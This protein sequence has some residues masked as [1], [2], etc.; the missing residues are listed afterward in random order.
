MRT[1]YRVLAGLVALGVVIQAAA[2]VYAVAGLGKYIDDGATINADVFEDDS[3]SFTGLGGFM[4]HGMNGMMIIPVLA[5]LL[6]IVSFF[7]KVPKGVMWA[8]LILLDVIL[9]VMLGIFGHEI[10]AV[11][12]LHGINAL[13][14][15]GLAVMA[16]MRSREP[17]APA[18][19]TAATVPGTT[20]TV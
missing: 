10:P 4:L 9:Q 14:L 17:A 20:T 8:G 3:L 1:A 12:A 19:G 7:A 6:L 13:I 2:I 15:F 16:V 5:L 18:P 11:G